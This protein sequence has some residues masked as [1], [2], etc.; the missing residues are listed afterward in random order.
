[1]LRIEP[2]DLYSVV[3]GTVW[4]DGGAMFGVV[5]KVLW[6]KVAE[7]DDANRIRLAT[8]TLLA[9]DR[10]SKRVILVDT[11]C[12]TKWLP[13]RAERFGIRHDAD[14]LRAALSAIG[15]SPAEVTDVVVT[16]LHFDHNGGLTEWFDDPGGETRLCYPKARHWIHAR[17]WDH[18]RNPHVKDRAS[19]L[20][21]DFAR[22]ADYDGLRLVNG[23]R[24]DAPFP[25]VEWLVTN[26]HT[27]AQLHP[28]FGTGSQRLLFVGDAC[29]TVAHLRLGWVMAYD[30]SPMTTIDEKTSVYRR[31]LD[32]GLLL[33]FPHDAEVAGVE[34]DG[35][36]ERPIVARTLPL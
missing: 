11:G 2:F 33:A 22:L 16:H 8:R 14:A 17:H 20:T 23:D 10:S 24:P 6:E 26:G 31:C 5:P 27:P 28:V 35:T 25:G 19:F 34:I 9:V 4:L 36:I 7:V 32:E 15:L 21:E 1:M 12:G 18:A 30:V 13:D 3:T 29:P